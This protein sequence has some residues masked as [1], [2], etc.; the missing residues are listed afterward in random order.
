MLVKIVVVEVS[1]V[2]NWYFWVRRHPY[3]TSVRFSNFYP[4]SPLVRRCPHWAYP[5][6]SRTFGD[7]FHKANASL[8]FC[9]TLDIQFHNFW[10]NEKFAKL[11]IINYNIYLYFWSYDSHRDRAIKYLNFETNV[12][13]HFCLTPVLPPHVCMCSLLLKPLPQSCGRLLWMT[14]KLN[15]LH[16]ILFKLR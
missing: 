6:S 10:M 2:S 16:K 4:S 7:H 8:I 15:R 14:P 12:N 11:K 9:E 13:V 1:L 5:P 3:K